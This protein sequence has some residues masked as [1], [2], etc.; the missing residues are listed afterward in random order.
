MKKIIKGILLAIVN[1]VSLTLVSCHNNSNIPSITEEEFFENFYH[2][3]E[4]EDRYVL[5][6]EQVIK[7]SYGYHKNDEQGY[8]NWFYHQKNKDGYSMLSYNP[9]KL[10]WEGDNAIIKEDLMEGTNVTRTYVIPK[11]GTI[12]IKGK[13]TSLI[14]KSS[15]VIYK[16]NEQIFPK[17]EDYQIDDFEDGY[18]IE[19]SIEILENEQ[20]H[21]VING[22][23][24]F[25][26]IISYTDEEVLYQ[27]PD[28]GFYG[29][30]HPF[31]YD[32]IM[33]M[34]NLQGYLENPDNERLLWCLHESKDMFHY[35]EIDYQVFDFVKNH[36][37]ATIDVYESIF[38]KET[39]QWGSRDMFLFYDHIAKKYVYFGLCY[40]RD[41][42]SCLGVR[43]S[44]DQEGMSWSTPMTS[45]R[46]FPI[47]NDPECS[48]AMFIN[49]R[50]YIF[51]SIWGESIHSVGRPMYLIGDEGKAFMDN[52]WSKKEM[53][54]LDGEDLCAYQLVDIGGRYLMYGW[55]PKTSYTNTEEIYFNGERDHGLWGGNIN[56]AR[57]VYPNSDGT[58]ST[59]LDPKMKSLLNRGL[60][61]QNNSLTPN[62]N[63]SN[64]F[65]RSFVNF[66]V[67]MNN[68]SQF[69]YVLNSQGKQY[70][71]TL[72]K[73]SSGVYL[74]ISC[75]QDKG[76]PLASMLRIGD[77]LQDKYKF[78]LII[79]KSILEVFVNDQFC[80]TARTSMF[81]VNHTVS[82]SSDGN[83]VIEN[84]KINKLASLIDVYD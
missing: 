46:D 75:S 29:D 22:K 11:E 10:L 14:E 76:H 5:S 1:I 62:T 67:S 43:V 71:I 3:E 16:N 78:D 54:Y 4:Q 36:Y 13:I 9:G 52:D 24:S 23:V 49:N 17:D 45:L 15:L 61:Y 30:V 70:L 69:S 84:L 74:T 65:K 26:P 80:L 58:L 25:N 83:A 21:F 56:M 66:E 27:V 77:R 72:E 64:T 57:E 18:Y 12:T 44:D 79:D 35:R 48:Q 37:N 40:Y 2:K 32:G 47:E 34:Y 68:A 60:C 63:I 41:R 19:T 59:K 31:Y 33:Y 82:F 51:T 39:F 8:N 7:A 42:S 28:W 53:H 50:W 38:D 6:D 73:I 20:I 55:I 81:D